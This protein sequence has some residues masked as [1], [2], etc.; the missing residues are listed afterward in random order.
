MERQVIFRQTENSPV[1]TIQPILE[2]LLF[3][4]TS[5]K[6]WYSKVFND[7]IVEKWKIEYISQIEKNNGFH[8]I[9]VDGNFESHISKFP[10]DKNSLFDMVIGFARTTAQGCIHKK[11]CE[12]DDNQSL[13]DLCI[14]DIKEECAKDSDIYGLQNPDEVKKFIEKIE[15]ERYLDDYE[16]NHIKCKCIA[17]DFELHKYVEYIPNGVITEK[18]HDKLLLN[19]R[20]MMRQEDIDWHPGSKNQVRDL[21]H[22]S[23][24]CYVKGVSFIQTDDGEYMEE[25]GFEEERYQWL[26]SEVIV[27]DGKIQFTSYVN[28]LN[29]EKY[30]NLS[31]TLDECFEAFL[32]SLEKIFKCDLSN[33]NLQVIVKIGSIHLDKNEKYEGGS[34]HIEGMPYEY[35]GATCIHYVNIEGITDSYLEFRKPVLLHPEGDVD[36]PQSDGSFTAHHYGLTPGFHHEGKMNRYLGLIKAQTGASIVFPNT[37]QHRVKDFEAKG[38]KGE[39]IIL[40]FFVIDP[41][42]RVLSTKDVLPQQNVFTRKQTEYH[43]ERLM[44]HRKYFYSKLN[45]EIFEREYSLCE[46]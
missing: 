29:Y 33:A 4:V 20:K 5:K 8:H 28:N 40:A 46:H 11:D 6:D 23:L 9:S 30:V 35:I 31:E 17:P 21:I 44:F 27:E 22:P 34:W 2:S 36:Y 1:N 42:M 16:C 37:L 7:K 15:K 41:K 10:I 25:V 39:R 43:R 32:P 18:L 38:Q 14:V 12:W 13:C 26:P 45:E 24:Y 3:E 19:V